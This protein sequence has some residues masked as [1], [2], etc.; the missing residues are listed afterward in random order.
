MEAGKTR[1]LQLFCW[2]S[3]TFIRFL[4]YQSLWPPEVTHNRRKFPW[5]GLSFGSGDPLKVEDFP[6]S[7]RSI[8]SAMKETEER[9]IR[10]LK[11]SFSLDM[12]VIFFYV[13]IKIKI[14]VEMRWKWSKV[15][16]S[17]QWLLGTKECGGGGSILPL[18]LGQLPLTSNNPH[19]CKYGRGRVP[20]HRNQDKQ[21]SDPRTNLL[22]REIKKSHTNY[23]FWADDMHLTKLCAV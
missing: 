16:I 8:G 19:C 7:G 11:I 10:K 23:G 9:W 4:L 5:N 13:K 20:F 17:C 1:S 12:F 18:I 22:G 21:A 15:Q 14:T 6:Q 2:K 3:F